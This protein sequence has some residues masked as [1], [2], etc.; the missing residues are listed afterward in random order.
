MF[1]ELPD[2]GHG[3]RLRGFDYLFGQVYRLWLRHIK[4]PLSPGSMSI[5]K[6][7]AFAIA[8]R[9]RRWRAKKISTRM[10]ISRRLKISEEHFS[11][12]QKIISASLNS[13][14]LYLHI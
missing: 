3:A 5:R 2:S 12:I 4:A 9:W 10:P 8:G 14:H 13:H 6:D 11:W 7:S 1:K